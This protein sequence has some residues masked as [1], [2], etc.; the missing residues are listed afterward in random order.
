MSVQFF[1]KLSQNYIE[2]LEDDEHYDVTIEVGE[3]PNVKIF[4]AHMIILCHRS[5]F[6]R[7]TLTL[8][9]KNNNGVLN[10]IKLSNVSP[11]A[12]QIIL[13]YIYGG[14]F[15]S[16]GR[17][18]LDIFNVLIA[19][20]ELLLNELVDYLQKYF[21]E[22][23]TEWMEQNFELTLR[24]SFKSNYLFEIQQFCTDL[25]VKYPEKMFKTLD[26]ES[27]PEKSLISLIKR[28]DLQMKEIEVWKYV[29]KWGLA[30]C[31]IHNSKPD[32]WKD[33]DF[34]T[35]RNILKD[36][37][38]LIRFYSLSSEEFV[39]KVRPY[40]KLLNKEIY[41]EVLRS[42]LESNHEPGDNILLPRYKIIDN[43]IISNIVNLNIISTISRWID[44]V[45]FNSNFSYLRELY[46][47][48]KFVLLLRGSRD[49]FSPRKFHELCDNKPNTIVF[50]KVKGTGEIL[51]GH[52]PSIW[53]SSGGWN[54]SYYSFIF[55]FKDKDNIK[56]SILSRIKIIDKALYYYDFCGPSFGGS[57]LSLSVC[58]FN[59]RANPS[60]EYDDNICKQFNYE[61]SIRDTEDHFCIEDYEV[62]QIRRK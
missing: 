48:Y 22:N 11:E 58:R 54:Q 12:F 15:S 50:I 61:K 5:S 39:K 35:I 31:K 14:I 40:K 42:Y 16:N 29:L 37:L 52:N 33:N 59:F 23:K 24:I 60:K 46:L 53:R 1:S 30:Q 13:R 38:P 6:L 62:F 57:D 56:D 34:K 47:P 28:D 21:I 32:T 27:I 51:G 25:M 26:F 44:K 36:C 49:G 10:N 55:S 2:I 17:D 18:T 45:D 19:A 3:D 4:R 20:D 7:Q 43:I 9:K 41:D 8:N